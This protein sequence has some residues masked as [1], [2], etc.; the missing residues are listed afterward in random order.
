M[1]EQTTRLIVHW[2]S[3]YKPTVPGLLFNQ[4]GV[5]PVHFLMERKMLLGIKDRVERVASQVPEQIVPTA[6]GEERQKKTVALSNY[7]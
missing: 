3:D 7:V 4:D 6:P 1:N 5:E 2:Q